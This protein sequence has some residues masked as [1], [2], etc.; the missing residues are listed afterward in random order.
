MDRPAVDRLEWLLN[1]VA[2]R[3]ER[4]TEAEWNT[5]YAPG[6]WTKKQVLGHLIDSATNNHQ[7]F[8]RIQFED[9][10]VIRYAQND[11]NT[12]SYHTQQDGEMLVATWK[13]YNV[14]LLALLRQIPESA[15]ERTGI[16]GEGQPFT[17]AYIVDDYVDHMEHHLNQI[18]E[19]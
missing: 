7:R 14:F 1:T 13:Q 10:P 9:T 15:L 5:P 11:W 3:L 2:W 16:G 6:K 12:Y 19:Y 4:W 18:I 8:V 17:L